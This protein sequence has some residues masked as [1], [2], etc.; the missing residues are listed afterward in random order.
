MLYNY[1]LDEN[2]SKTFIQRIILAT[3][4]NKEKK[5]YHIL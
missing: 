5:T 1:K 2:I 3:D 4:P